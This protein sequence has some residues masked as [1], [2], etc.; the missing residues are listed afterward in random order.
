MP[1]QL[2]PP[3][4]PPPASHWGSRAQPCVAASR[5]PS[6]P[7]ARVPSPFSQWAQPH[8]LRSLSSLWGVLLRILRW[9]RLNPV[10]TATPAQCPPPPPPPLQMGPTCKM[11]QDEPAW[12]AKNAPGSCPGAGD[13]VGGSYAQAH[14]E[15]ES[16]S[17]LETPGGPLGGEGPS[18]PPDA[19][20]GCWGKREVGGVGGW[21]RGMVWS[22]PSLAVLLWPQ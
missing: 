19:A 3:L 8:A 4:S 14:G 1:R 5:G 9:K 16:S 22:G 13:A 6:C 15:S 11:W 12:P 2:C 7:P 20:A 21:G 18:W 17:R 10:P